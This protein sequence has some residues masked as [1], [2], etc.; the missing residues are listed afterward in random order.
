MV[1]YSYK[2]LQ[3]DGRSIRLLRLMPSS[4]I[5]AKV[6][7]E[8]FHAEIDATTTEEMSYEA[9]SYTWGD[10][11]QTVDIDISGSIFPATVSLEAALRCLRK[12][13]E[14]RVLWVD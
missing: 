1:P 3:Q 4:C 8:I 10:V 14:P 2:S 7:C 9:L 6:A 5:I 11:S 13:N 12:T